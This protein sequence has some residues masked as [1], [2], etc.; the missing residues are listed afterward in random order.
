M[1]FYAGLKYILCCIYRYGMPLFQIV[2]FTC[3]NYT[4]CIALVFMERETTNHYAWALRRLK[5]LYG[6]KNP[7]CIMSD[8]ELGLIKAA[9]L[10]FPKVRHHLCQVHVDRN[11]KAYAKT[12]K[13]DE[14]KF[15]GSVR[16]VMRSHTKEEYRERL[17]HFKGIWSEGLVRYVE[18]TWFNE[19][20]KKLVAAWCDDVLHFATRTSN[21]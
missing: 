15:S 18:Q 1:V 4:Y 9:K 6:E 21:R 12:M 11:V 5:W 20:K 14:K 17:A 16:R 13:I 7:V 10:V 8:R 3:T 19:H 2:G